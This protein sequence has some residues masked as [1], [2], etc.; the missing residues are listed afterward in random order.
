MAS[1]KKKKRLPK[2]RRVKGCEETVGESTRILDLGYAQRE[3]TGAQKIES[4]YS[5]CIRSGQR[6]RWSS[7]IAIQKVQNSYF[8]G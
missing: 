7:I 6:L 5:S 2:K 8:F 3:L 4:T 1:Q